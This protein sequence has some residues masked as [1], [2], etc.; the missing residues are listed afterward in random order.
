MLIHWWVHWGKPL[1]V[2]IVGGK[3]NDNSSEH[4]RIIWRRFTLF[5]RYSA[6]NYF[7]GEG[8][9]RR[10]LRRNTVEDEIKIKIKNFKKK[11]KK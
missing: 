9:E 2:Y 1:L 11:S 5:A 8:K 3:I 6:Q 10:I 7:T 4:L